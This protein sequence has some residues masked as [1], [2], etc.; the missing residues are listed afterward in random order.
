MVWDP[1]A[2]RTLSAKTHHSRNDFNI[3]EGMEVTGGAA[4][5]MS[6]GTV[7]WQGGN[8]TPR[9]GHGRYI[10]RPCFGDATRSQAIRNTFTAPTAVERQEFVP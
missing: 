1:N 5:T 6:R 2:T 10:N 7:L 4:V 9:Q 8:L 3:F